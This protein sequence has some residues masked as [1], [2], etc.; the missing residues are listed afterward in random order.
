LVPYRARSTQLHKAVHTKP[1]DFPGRACCLGPDKCQAVNWIGAGDGTATHGFHLASKAKD[2][3]KFYDAPIKAEGQS[4]RKPGLRGK[5]WALLSRD[6]RVGSTWM[7]CFAKQWIGANGDRNNIDVVDK[8]AHRDGMCVV[9]T[10]K[11]E[12]SMITYV[13]SVS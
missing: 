9:I 1:F 13:P 7:S 10:E 3:D 4:S 5:V 12:T 11:E 8:T 6:S 2:H